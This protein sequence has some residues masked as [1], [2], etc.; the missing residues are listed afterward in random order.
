MSSVAAGLRKLPPHLRRTALQDWLSMQEKQ[1][2]E[3]FV[4][5][6]RAADPTGPSS[7]AVRKAE[8]PDGGSSSSAASMAG[9]EL[10]DG[11]SLCESDGTRDGKPP[12]RRHA[13][14]CDG[15]PLC[16]DADGC[17]AS[18]EHDTEADCDSASPSH[19]GDDG[20][21]QASSER[22]STQAGPSSVRCRGIH[23][24]GDGRYKVAIGIRSVRIAT[25]IARGL[26]TASEHI[27]V[28]Q[29]IKT[30]FFRDALKNEDD[31]M[32]KLECAIAA[33]MCEHG[34]TPEA[35][36]LTF[37]LEMWRMYLAG[38]HVDTPVMRRMSDLRHAWETLEQPWFRFSSTRG[39]N[40]LF[41]FGT[42][43]LEQHWE[44]FQVSY[45]A[46]CTAHGQKEERV[47]R[48]LKEAHENGRHYRERQWELWGTIRMRIEEKRATRRRSKEEVLKLQ[49]ERADMVSNDHEKWR[50]NNNWR[51]WRRADQ[52][53]RVVSNWRDHRRL[54]E[55]R[56]EIAVLRARE[57]HAKAHQRRFLVERR[58]ERRSA[59]ERWM[60]MRGRDPCAEIWARRGD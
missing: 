15:V 47:I 59:R 58:E 7:V 26:Q 37:Y 17:E 52:L 55:R 38:G 16:D 53:R 1:E 11:S 32:P 13:A 18:P 40:L 12:K 25:K 36:G 46:L 34:T 20:D 22:H 45:K 21:G 27:V 56:R 44:S 9:C 50:S 35:I 6:Q 2:L 51:A 42:D 24:I 14:L 43:M 57:L 31:F 3:A 23:S 5:S 60:A 39:Y 49:R 29:S 48:R 19:S 41:R 54:S 10:A 33:S 30:H 8:S 4:T 28:L